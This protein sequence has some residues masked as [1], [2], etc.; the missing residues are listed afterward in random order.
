M[1]NLDALEA[2]ARGAY[3]EWAKWSVGPAAAVWD[4]L[5]QAAQEGWQQVARSALQAHDEASWSSDFGSAPR[6]EPIQMHARYGGQLIRRL[7]KDENPIQT[8]THWRRLPA[9]PRD[10]R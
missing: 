3:V 1:A 4:Q 9:N 8:M 5:P 2:A 10:Y 7:M 6:D